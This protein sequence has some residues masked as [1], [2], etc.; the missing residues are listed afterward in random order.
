[1]CFWHI[2]TRIKIIACFWIN[3]KTWVLIYYDMESKIFYFLRKDS[4]ALVMRWK[5][6]L[7]YDHKW[8]GKIEFSDIILMY[9]LNNMK[10][11]SHKLWFL[12]YKSIMINYVLKCINRVRAI[13][14]TYTLI[15]GSLGRWKAI[16][17]TSA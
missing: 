1:M 15:T 12:N 10:I 7:F 5:L 9:L 3:F 17:V 4:H 14:N 13:L 11:L 16:I 8:G 2:R 6:E